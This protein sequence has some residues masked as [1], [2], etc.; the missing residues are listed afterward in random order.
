MRYSPYFIPLCIM[1][2][3]RKPEG[4]HQ[5]G[6]LCRRGAVHRRHGN[7]KR[8][9]PPKKIPNAMYNTRRPGIFALNGANYSPP[10]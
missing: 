4:F 9:L 6:Y 10:G 8:V 2:Y 3:F 5:W 1:R 7:E